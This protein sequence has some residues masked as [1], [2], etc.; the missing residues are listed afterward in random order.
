[1]GPPHWCNAAL[2]PRGRAVGGPRE[3]QEAQMARPRG[4]GPHVHVVGEVGRWRAH[5]YSGRWL[6]IGG[7]NANALPH[8]II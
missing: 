1:M 8:P 6:G 7:G 4:R 3:A 2:R 5:G